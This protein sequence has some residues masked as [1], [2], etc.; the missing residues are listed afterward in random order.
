MTLAR[1][2]GRV[3]GQSSLAVVTEGFRSVLEAQGV[4]AGVCPVDIIEVPEEETHAGASARHGVYTGHLGRLS[5]MFTRGLHQHYWIML[6]P[7]S[8]RLPPDLV[9]LISGYAATTRRVHLMAPSAWAS[10]IVE[11]HFPG[12]GPCFT[13]PHGVDTARYKVNAARAEQMRKGSGYGE[14][15]VLHFSTSAQSRKGTVEL[16]QA[17]K[18]LES[19]AGWDPARA[20]LLC[21]MDRPAQET[22]MAR[23]FEEDLTLPSTVRIIPRADLTPEQMA[24]NLAWS[25]VVCQPSRGEAFGLIPLEALCCGVPVVATYC[26]GHSEYL[27]IGGEAMGCELITTDTDGPLDDLPGSV[28]PRLT[29]EEIARALKTARQTWGSLQDEALKYA[30]DWQRLWSW[31]EKLAP[32]VELLR[33]T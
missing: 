26:T 31:K 14:F 3:Q 32:F 20:T 15:R 25:H 30:P 17:W 33:N 2:Y 8:N 13:A 12:Q 21:V 19:Q 29:P 10:K 4:L 16:V 1:L 7:N 24:Q 28:G 6:A 5:M 23:L 11:A 27:G 9:H 18:L 22:L